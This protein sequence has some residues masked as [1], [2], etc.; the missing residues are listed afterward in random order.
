MTCP[1]E[2][3]GTFGSSRVTSGLLVCRFLRSSTGGWRG[4]GRRGGG[5]HWVRLHLGHVSV[6]SRA[7][8]VATWVEVAAAGGRSPRSPAPAVGGCGLGA[9]TVRGLK[10][11]SWVF[12]FPR[13]R[14][15]APGQQWPPEWPEARV[16]HHAGLC[17]HPEQVATE[18]DGGVSLSITSS[19][20]GLAGPGPRAALRPSWGGRGPSGGAFPPL[21]LC[22]ETLTGP[23]VALTTV[24]TPAR[25]K[26]DDHVTV[27]LPVEV[28]Q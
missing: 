15:G 27:L 10:Q 23:C 26:G 3:A 5:S 14:C 1:T 13:A 2:F 16:P 19:P 24:K 9:L 7:G 6:A 21:S 4:G 11:G 17:P 22:P 25:W 18:A 12:S 20:R 8:T 28:R